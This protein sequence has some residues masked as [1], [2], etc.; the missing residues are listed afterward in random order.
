MQYDIWNSKLYVD[1]KI[2]ITFIER[3]SVDMKKLS[4]W[5]LPLLLFCLLLTGCG[6]NSK[7][8]LQQAAQDAVQVDVKQTT[9][10]SDTEGTAQVVIGIPNYTKLFA[11]GK[12]AKDIEKYLTKALKKGNYEVLEFEKTVPVIVEDGEQLVQTEEATKQLL[13]QELIQAINQSVEEGAH[14]EKDN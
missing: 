5:L 4:Y 11:E 3:M 10:T 1:Y 13:E 8:A 12:D 6:G 7:E 9:M 14:D 2:D